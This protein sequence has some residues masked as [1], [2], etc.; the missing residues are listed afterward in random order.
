MTRHKLNPAFKIVF[1]YE[2]HTHTHSRVSE[3]RNIAIVNYVEKFTIDRTVRM[4]SR[5]NIDGT[6]L[7][8]GVSLPPHA[9]PPPPPLVYIR[10]R[11]VV[12]FFLGIYIKCFF[13]CSLFPTPHCHVSATIHIIIYCCAKK[14]VCVCVCVIFSISNAIFSYYYYK[15]YTRTFGIVL[16]FVYDGI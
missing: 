6:L 12:R 3:R 15:P 1:L 9:L 13:F 5:L 4:C 2:T 11:F 14:F 7:L 8:H 16:L 10:T